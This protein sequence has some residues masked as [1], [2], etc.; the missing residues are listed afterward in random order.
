MGLT[1]HDGFIKQGQLDESTVLWHLLHESVTFVTSVISGSHLL[2]HNELINLL[3]VSWHCHPFQTFGYIAWYNKRKKSQGHG[4]GQNLR[5]SVQ[6]IYFFFVLWQ[7]IYSWDMA[8][9]YLTL[10]I[11]GQDHGQGQNLWSH[12]RPNKQS[13]YSVIMLTSLS[14]TNYFLSN[15]NIF[16]SF[17]HMQNHPRK[18][19]M[20]QRSCKF[21]W[22][23]L[24]NYQVNILTL[25]SSW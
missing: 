11:Q 14:D 3:F 22:S 4:Q 21:C 13:I 9:T 15:M 12:L 18:C 7:A 1:V 8:I 16:L 17:T 6:M 25:W 24:N 10:K 19:T 5:H 23:T 20:S 2:P